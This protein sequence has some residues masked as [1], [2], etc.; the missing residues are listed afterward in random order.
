M[1]RREPIGDDMN[2]GADV[3]NGRITISQ[4]LS[5]RFSSSRVRT[6][7]RLTWSG[8][9]RSS[10]FLIYTTTPTVKKVK[11]DVT[12]FTEYALTWWDQV[13]SNRRRNNDRP[14]ETWEDMKTIMKKQ[15]VLAQYY[16]ELHKH[17]LRLTQGSKSVEDY[18]QDM[19]MI[20][21]CLGLE[22]DEEVI[23]AQFI[24]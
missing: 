14:V 6:T 21:I 17:L 24:A 13:A 4:A 11:I 1:K 22:E 20:M 5:K 2:K 23:M 12:E 10:M 16:Q 8:K 3:I 7:P 19:E 9:R 15:F 18:H